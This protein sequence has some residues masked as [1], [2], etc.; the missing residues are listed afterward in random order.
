MLNFLHRSI[1]MI[2]LVIPSH[3]RVQPSDFVLSLYEPDAINVTPA[4]KS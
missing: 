3:A 1:L 4:A 2:Q